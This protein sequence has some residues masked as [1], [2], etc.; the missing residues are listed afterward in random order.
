M[1]ETEDMDHHEFAFSVVGRQ[2]R[3][4]NPWDQ[5]IVAPTLAGRK[6]R[7]GTPA[8]SS[9]G[10]QAASEPSRGQLAP[11]SASSTASGR[12]RRSPSG[13]SKTRAPSRQPFHVERVRIVGVHVE[14]GEGGHE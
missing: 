2:P 9:Q 6:G 8:G 12:S 10:V 7:T 14:H 11:P 1:V 13:V 3:Q 4:G 5:A